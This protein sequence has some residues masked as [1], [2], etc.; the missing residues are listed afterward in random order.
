[1]IHLEKEEE[2]APHLQYYLK[3]FIKKIKQGELSQKH[4][5]VQ[6]QINNRTGAFLSVQAENYGRSEQ[7]ASGASE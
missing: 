7:T 3:S 4:F 6:T 5:S 2:F 1:M